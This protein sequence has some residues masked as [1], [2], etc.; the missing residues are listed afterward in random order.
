MFN[1]R[2][3]KSLIRKSLNKTPSQ[4][5]CKLK[6]YAIIELKMDKK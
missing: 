4:I 2:A 5:N 3:I 1:N 6:N